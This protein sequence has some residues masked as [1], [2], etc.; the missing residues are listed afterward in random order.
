M[1]SYDPNWL[2]QYQAQ[3][4]GQMPPDPMLGGGNTFANLNY[5]KDKLGAYSQAD[6]DARRAEIAKLKGTSAWVPDP[7]TGVLPDGSY[8][9][10]QE[11]RAMAGGG[12]TQPPQGGGGG[13]G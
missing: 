1:T 12:N 7:R 3:N 10:G 13:N 8:P 11:W 5:N 2:R 6:V 4:N 9:A